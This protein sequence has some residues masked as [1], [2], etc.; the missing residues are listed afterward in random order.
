MSGWGDRW[1]SQGGIADWGLWVGVFG[2]G[3]LVMAMRAVRGGMF[4]KEQHVA[5][6]RGTVILEAPEGAILWEE[7]KM[8][9]IAMAGRVV[10]L[11]ETAGRF[12]HGCHD[13]AQC[14]M[15]Q[16]TTQ[17]FWGRMFSGLRMGRGR[18]AFSGSGGGSGAVDAS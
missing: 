8:M 12:G 15:A 2:G 1:M 6:A 16:E 11:V 17:P 5:A 10:G 7:R 4:R 9:S 3:A 14:D 18:A 13:A